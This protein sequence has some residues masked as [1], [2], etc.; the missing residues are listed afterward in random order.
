MSIWHFKYGKRGVAFPKI[1]SILNS[2]V[3]DT[4]GFSGFV[5]LAST[6][7]SNKATIITF[8]KDKTSL[9]ASEKGVFADAMIEIGGLLEGALKAR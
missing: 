5:S 9:E 3:K 8:W 4:E 6:D 1:D 7:D 2:R